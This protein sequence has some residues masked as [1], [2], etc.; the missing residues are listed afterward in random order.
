MHAMK[1]QESSSLHGPVCTT[2]IKVATGSSGGK[3]LQSKKMY[4][5]NR[6]GQHGAWGKC[7]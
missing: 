6:E 4:S 2:P 5:I 1:I 3:M 7:A